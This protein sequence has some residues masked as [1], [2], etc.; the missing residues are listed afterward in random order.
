[1][2]TSDVRA[3]P[4]DASD[5]L[6]YGYCIRRAGDPSPTEDLRGIG[7]GPVLLLETD[8]LG[9][10]LSEAG[11]GSPPTA[12]R[13]REH[14]RVVR[15]ALRTA[16]PLPLRYGSRFQASSDAAAALAERQAEFTETLDR[17]AG[18]VEMGIR[19]ALPA[20][21]SERPASPPAVVR[22]AGSGRAYLEGRRQ[23]LAEE[24]SALRDADAV[25][26][27]IEADLADL[28]APAVRSP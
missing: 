6:L 4:Y 19:V 23:E 20:G 9:I 24:A 28:E 11:T 26:A 21:S 10:W 15:A 5:E 3:A 13:L 25:L 17:V 27:G 8:S 22:P 14:E 12:D 7:G 1:M 16:T 2:N 18:M